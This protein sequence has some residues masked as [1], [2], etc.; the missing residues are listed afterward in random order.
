MG[1]VSA[2]KTLLI[3]RKSSIQIDDIDTDW[4][5][6]EIWA[7][8]V[9]AAIK[10]ISGGSTH[11]ASL[12]GPGETVSPGALTQDG[13]FTIDGDTTMNGNATVQLTG[14]E[15]FIVK[16]GGTDPGITVDSTSVDIQ[17]DAGALPGFIHVTTT[18]VFIFPGGSGLLGFFGSGSSNQVMVT[19]SRGGNAALASLLT[20]LADYGLIIN[21]SSP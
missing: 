20:A 13:D 14:P 7:Q 19:G 1:L 5:A 15:S 11:Y 2:L 17:G 6:I 3:P 18:G 10:S 8:Q 16:S 4:R 21:S 9:V 12:T